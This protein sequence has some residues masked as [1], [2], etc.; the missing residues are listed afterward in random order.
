MSGRRKLL[1][2]ALPEL[3]Q[4][5]ERLLAKD[6]HESL[7]KQIPQL[8]L[9]DRCRCEDAFCATIYTAPRPDGTWG[10]EHENVVLDPEKGML[11]LD[12]VRGVVSC[13]EVLYRDDVRQ[14]VL[15]QCP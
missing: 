13:I 3:A 2:E 7:A 14:A 15:E 8:E 11:V 9:V 1:R 12:V 10:P 4:E 6:G 5:V